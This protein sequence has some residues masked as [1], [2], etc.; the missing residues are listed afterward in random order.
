MKEMAMWMKKNTPGCE[1]VL[2]RSVRDSEEHNLKTTSIF[3]DTGWINMSHG[4]AKDFLYERGLVVKCY[5]PNHIPFTL[6]ILVIC[7]I[8][9]DSA[10]LILPSNLLNW[11]FR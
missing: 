6:S 7:C 3:L 4:L 5:Y 10:L 9:R 1:P 2:L 11:Y 8:I